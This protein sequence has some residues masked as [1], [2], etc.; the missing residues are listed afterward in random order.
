MKQLLTF[1]FLTFHLISH[2]QSFTES[3][4]I[5]HYLN[6]STQK[7]SVNFLMNFPYDGIGKN[8]LINNLSN[9]LINNYQ[10]EYVPKRMYNTLFGNVSMGLKTP[11]RFKLE[12]QASQQG[13]NFVT[14]GSFLSKKIKKTQFRTTTVAE[15]YNYQKDLDKNEDNFQDLP[16]KQRLTLAH[17]TSFSGPKMSTSLKAFY[18]NSESTGGDLAFDKT[19]DHLK[20]SIYGYGYDFE[21]FGAALNTTIPIKLK[22]KTKH[23][24][25][26][27]NI[28]GSFHRQSNFYGVKKLIGEEDLLNI[29]AGYQQQNILSTFGLLATRRDH[30]IHQTYA[31]SAQDIH[32]ERYSLF[33]YYNTF[34][35][36]SNKISISGRVDYENDKWEFYPRAQLDILVQ[37]SKKRNNYYYRNRKRSSYLS[38]FAG[39]EKRLS[40][41]LFENQRYFNSNREFSS[42]IP[43]EIYDKGWMFGSS[44]TLQEVEFELPFY[45]EYVY[46]KN[47]KL[48]WR[49]LAL[50]EQTRINIPTFN[51]NEFGYFYRDNDL[52]FQHLLEF[53]TTF[54]YQRFYMTYLMRAQ[55]PDENTLFLPRTSSITS[56]KYDFAFGLS[57]NLS[58]YHVGKQNLIDGTKSGSIN[59]W[60]WRSQINLQQFWQNWFTQKT[61]FY[62]GINNI[63][64]QTKGNTY[65]NTTD[66]FNGNFDGA[67]IWGN[68][69]GFQF[70]G[71]FSM[72]L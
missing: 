2:S 49:T 59:R 42:S 3:P 4:I 25:I 68:T 7:G 23:G 37:F 48:L 24:K 53:T 20:D 26:I 14:V 63:T 69:V 62:L 44:F 51:S 55:F 13:E 46:I 21:H 40:L 5:T 27:A 54:R 17:H 47:T 9:R 31:T 30:S 72:S 35:G 60:D 12:Y 10:A 39:R 56:F 22:N 66:P 43:D 1:I 18:I 45:Y 58:W 32:I 64:G 57:T 52:D 70:H 41:P 28:D 71:G 38:F 34:W 61:S 19:R 29:T 16:Q 15:G 65:S 50:T 36:K 8:L 67:S 33:G 11:S 6:N